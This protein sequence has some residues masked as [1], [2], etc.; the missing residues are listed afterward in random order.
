MG[1]ANYTHNLGGGS[2]LTAYSI[3]PAVGKEAL[4]Q[5]VEDSLL[6]KKGKS[7]ADLLALSSSIPRIGVYDHFSGMSPQFSFDKYNVPEQLH[8]FREAIKLGF[9]ES[10]IVFRNGDISVPAQFI[11]GEYRD[12]VSTNLI[13]IPAKTVP[14]KYPEGK[15]IAQLLPEFGLSDKDVAKWLGCAHFMTPSNGQEFSFVYRGKTLHIAPD[16]LALSGSTTKFPDHFN[17]ESFNIDNYFRSHLAGEME[18]E[19][20][21]KQDEFGI[22]KVHLM[23]DTA[24]IPFVAVE[25]KTD[26]ST[27]ELATK[28]YGQKQPMKEHPIFFGTDKSG[29]RKLLEQV[30]LFPSTAR[31][32][33][34]VSQ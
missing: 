1:V 16:C 31:V 21:L 33:D 20:Y 19:Y 12:F 7:P 15:T 34:L 5:C 18:E 14:G 22:G 24:Q 23:N 9:S 32:M 6:S 11:K 29:L 13:A 2:V 28:A 27:E 26:V 25:I 17:H 8:A 4:R 10:F 3:D 30:D